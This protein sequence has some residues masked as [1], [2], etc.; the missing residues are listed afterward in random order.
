MKQ[1]TGKTN[2][3][4]SVDKVSIRLALDGHSFSV[5]GLDGASESVSVEIL[6][7]RTILVPAELV[8]RGSKN[9]ES[10]A[11]LLAVA[12]LP[13]MSG[14]C[15]VCSSNVNGI[16]AI[17]A[18]P[19]AAVQQV[20]EHLKHRCYTTPLLE[21]EAEGTTLRIHQA[22]S[23]LYIKV[24]DESRLQMAEV[25]P[26]AE[27][28]DLLYFI[29][30]LEEVFPLKKYRAIISG[31]ETKRIRKIIGRKVKEVICE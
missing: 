24:Y 20:E 4:T 12:G 23:L 15:A 7:P 22:T 30:R 11:E 5:V 1:V 26:V 18:V 10:M 14:E 3:A 13:L 16:V 6:T 27:E 31:D 19:Q 2:S 9:T 25:I 17:M 21:I 29:E 28:S 8:E